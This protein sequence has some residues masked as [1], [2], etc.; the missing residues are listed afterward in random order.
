MI[1]ILGRYICLHLVS[2]IGSVKVGEFSEK[3]SVKLPCLGVNLPT[4]GLPSIICQSR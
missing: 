2:Q 4:L 3:A 1:P